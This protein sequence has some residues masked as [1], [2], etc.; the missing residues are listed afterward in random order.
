MKELIEEYWNRIDSDFSFLTNTR[1]IG[2][3]LT[4]ELK[5]DSNSVRKTLL[6]VRDYYLSWLKEK[7]EKKSF[8]DE[9]TESGF[10]KILESFLYS[11]DLEKIEASIYT[12]GKL[13]E[14]KYF[15]ALLKVFLKYLRLRDFLSSTHCLSEMLWLNYKRG[16]QFCEDQLEFGDIFIDLTVF[17]ALSSWGTSSLPRNY[18]KWHENSKLNNLQADDIHKQQ[19]ELAKLKMTIS[20]GLKSNSQI[21]NLEIQK[22]IIDDFINKNN[23]GQQ[24][25]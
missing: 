20:N 17:T 14:P 16:I 25:A 22:T 18:S 24:Q 1:D 15:D 5:R 8:I 4:Q 21:D 3:R 23:C 11:D 13:N 12:F 19:L 10:F 6:F 9:L 7:N 2:R